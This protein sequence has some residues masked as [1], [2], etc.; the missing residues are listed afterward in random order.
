MPVDTGGADADAISAAVSPLPLL[1][2]A[3]PELL[4]VLPIFLPVLPLLSG[5]AD[6]VELFAVFAAISIVLDVGTHSI[7]VCN[8]HIARLSV[9]GIAI[10]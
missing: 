9:A 4:P 8:G 7:R 6:T 10:V 1:P 5:G 2:E 3:L